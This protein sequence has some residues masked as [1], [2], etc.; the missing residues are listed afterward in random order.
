MPLA[1][2]GFLYGRFPPA[3]NQSFEG[4]KDAST[5]RKQVCPIFASVSHIYSDTHPLTRRA[6]ETEA[7][8]A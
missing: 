1:T 6:C 2:C 7:Y 5:Q 3:A 4:A 8:P